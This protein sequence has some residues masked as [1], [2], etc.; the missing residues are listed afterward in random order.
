MREINAGLDA[1]AKA[2]SRS[3]R[4]QVTIEANAMPTFTALTSITSN[5][6]PLRMQRSGDVIL[7]TG[8]PVAG[9]SI[10]AKKM[11]SVT[12]VAD[13]GAAGW[14]KV[15]DTTRQ[16]KHDMFLDGLDAIVAYAKFADADLYYKESGDGG[17]TWGAEQTFPSIPDAMSEAVIGL[18]CL[19]R[20]YVFYRDTTNARIR[21]AVIISRTAKGNPWS[22]SAIW[23]NGGFIYPVAKP[24]GGEILYCN[25]IGGVDI[26]SLNAIFQFYLGRGGSGQNTNLAWP[27]T[28]RAENNT[29]GIPEQ[30]LGGIIGPQDYRYDIMGCSRPLNGWLFA[31]IVDGYKTMADAGGYANSYEYMIGKTKD[32]I[33]FHLLPVS[34]EA[35]EDISYTSLANQI[36]VGPIIAQDDSQVCL[37]VART[38]YAG[39]FNGYAQVYLTDQSSY[40]GQEPSETDITDDVIG[41][42]S[43]SKGVR[44]SSTTEVRLTNKGGTYT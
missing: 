16:S 13:W 15:V 40:F 39:V 30:A 4:A 31:G 24:V 20:L 29:W 26:V 8:A 38:P 32:G 11:S 2:V 7:V 5:Y 27:L 25:Y 36:L 19:N 1:A 17:E 34:L 6:V 14:V 41:G 37:V 21:Y 18:S 43:I 44:E 9:S 12:E 22:L 10:Y 35:Q 23:P 28:I 42:I 33:S 3:P